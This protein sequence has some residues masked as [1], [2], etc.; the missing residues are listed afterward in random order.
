MHDKAVKDKHLGYE[1]IPCHLDD[2]HISFAFLCLLDSSVFALTFCCYVCVCF[3]SHC[4]SNECLL[5]AVHVQLAVLPGDYS[6]Q[7]MQ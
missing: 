1:P 5:L 7:P 3:Y 4:F 2:V 6:R